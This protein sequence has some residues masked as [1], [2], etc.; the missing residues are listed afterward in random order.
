MSA[1]PV[2]RSLNSDYAFLYL[3]ALAY[4]WLYLE[5]PSHP[6]NL[7]VMTLSSD[8]FFQ[9]AVGVCILGALTY[10]QLILLIFGYEGPSKNPKRTIVVFK[11]MTMLVSNCNLLD[12]EADN[13]LQFGSIAVQRFGWRS[14]IRILIVG[15]C[16]A[17]MFVLTYIAPFWLYHGITSGY[18]DTVFGGAIFLALVI[19][20]LQ[21]RV[22]PFFPDYIPPDAADTSVPEYLKRNELVRRN[23]EQRRLDE[24]WESD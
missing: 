24:E 12:V 22:W 2:F 10:H 15:I 16:P 11:H 8:L 20:L 23:T 4:G 3:P 19:A 5:S 6:V 7:V 1:G 21:A 9:L 18:S 13:Y 14:W 17:A